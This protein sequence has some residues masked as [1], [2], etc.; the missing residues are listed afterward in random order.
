M[1]ILIQIILAISVIVLQS[2]I[3]TDLWNWFVANTFLLP[4]LSVA[5][6]FGLLVFVGI[7][8]TRHKNSSDPID[9]EHK[10]AF[11]IV[12][13]IFWGLGYVVKDFI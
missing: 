9:W 5:N 2:V 12:C 13:L 6:M 11:Q 1:L 3:L 10:I 4:V 8:N 7:I